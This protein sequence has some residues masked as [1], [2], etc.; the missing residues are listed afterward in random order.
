MHVYMCICLFVYVYINI[1]THTYVRTYVYIRIHTHINMHTQPD[2]QTDRDTLTC[3]YTH[4]Y[5]HTL[6]LVVAAMARITPDEAK[7]LHKFCFTFTHNI[8]A[9][10][11]RTVGIRTNGIPSPTVL[12]YITVMY[13]KTV[14]QESTI[15]L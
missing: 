4:T 15:N 12:L 14:G 13:N 5:T 2:R 10:I 8:H 11:R 3:T 6:C 7:G 9:Y 1:Y